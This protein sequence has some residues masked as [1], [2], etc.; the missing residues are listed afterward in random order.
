MKTHLVSELNEP[1]LETLMS[2]FADEWWTS[3]RTIEDVR[4]MLRETRVVVGLVDDD[5]LV[6]FTRVLTDLRYG[7]TVLDVIVDPEHRGRGLGDV[8]MAAIIDHPDLQ[9][10]RGGFGL[11]CRED[12]RIFYERWGFE[13]RSP[14]PDAEPYG[15]GWDMARPSTSDRRPDA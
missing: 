8:L 13:T 12:K 4:V 3:D 5:G 6:G 9:D 11:K 1:Q 7:A 10:L 15:G 2:W 14:L